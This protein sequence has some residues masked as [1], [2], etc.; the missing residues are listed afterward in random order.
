MATSSNAVRVD[1]KAARDAVSNGQ[2]DNADSLAR[3]NALGGT[4]GTRFELRRNG[5]VVGQCP[6]AMTRNGRD[7]TFTQSGPFEFVVAADKDTGTWVGRFVN[8]SDD[9][10]YIELAITADLTV[11]ADLIVNGVGRLDA[12]VVRTPAYDT[13]GGAAFPSSSDPRVISWVDPNL[14]W[15]SQP[16]P[17]SPGSTMVLQVSNTWNAAYIVQQVPEPG[18][19]GSGSEYTFSRVADP[20]NGAKMAILHRT[21]SGYERWGSTY[22]SSYAQGNYMRDATS[23]WVA[24][25]MRID[26][27][28][29]NGGNNMGLFDVHHNNWDTGPYGRPSN[30][31]WAPFSINAEGGLAYIIRV[32]GCY[33]VGGTQA[34]I[35]STTLH[36]SGTVTAGD[37]HKIVV[38]IR[39]GRGWGDAPAVTVWRKI[40]SGSVSQLANRSDVPIS[41]YDVPADT[42]YMK[43]G[44]YQWDEPP[45]DRTMYTKGVMMFQDLAGTPTLTETALMALLDSL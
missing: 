19:I 44:M 2:R 41:Y 14:P 28:W 40:N 17:P 26:S 32:H 42:H 13:G 18:I 21:K 1:A 45:S 8:A 11:S 15:A 9:T 35:T 38:R 23:Y 16:Y 6:V 30:F 36:S 10:R 5:S 33:T 43:S 12:V 34:N 3:F 37:W 25:A 20:S 29:S 24:F 39:L 31:P 22:R 7:L 27:S 4:L